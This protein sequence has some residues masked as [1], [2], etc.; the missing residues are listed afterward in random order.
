MSCVCLDHVKV[1]QHDRD[2]AVKLIHTK[3]YTAVRTITVSPRLPTV[4]FVKSTR[5]VSVQMNPENKKARSWLACTFLARFPSS[6]RYVRDSACRRIRLMLTS[7]RRLMSWRHQQMKTWAMP[8]L[9][10][11]GPTASLRPSEA[12][13]AFKERLDSTY[14]PTYASIRRLTTNEHLF[15]SVGSHHTN[16]TYF[17]VLVYSPTTNRAHNSVVQIFLLH[18]GKQQLA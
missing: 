9:D 8:E 2:H 16:N 6:M 3:I 12:S 14:R 4:R 15:G 13:A 10:R 18:P 17:E 1:L 11:I 7:T 5:K